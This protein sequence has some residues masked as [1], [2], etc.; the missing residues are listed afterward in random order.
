MEGT[1]IIKMLSEKNIQDC[2]YCWPQLVIKYTSP[3]V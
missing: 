3:Y 1:Y 2:I